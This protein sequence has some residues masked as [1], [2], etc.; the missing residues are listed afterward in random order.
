MEPSEPL[1]LV[2]HKIRY[3]SPLPIA[4]V[5]C[6]ETFCLTFTLTLSVSAVSFCALTETP[7]DQTEWS[8][9]YTRT[10]Q[11]CT[12]IS[13]KLK[14][15]QR[16]SINFRTHPQVPSRM[17]T[18]TKVYRATFL[19]TSSASLGVTQKWQQYFRKLTWLTYRTCNHNTSDKKRVVLLH[20][21]ASQ[22]YFCS[23]S[24]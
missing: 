1:V 10:T 15:L 8:N 3:V 16:S 21:R 9:S 24:A 20:A 23:Q 13:A 12:E 5:H 11:L 19:F 7:T 4:N 14:Q 6:R 22:Y 17:R 2:P 18:T